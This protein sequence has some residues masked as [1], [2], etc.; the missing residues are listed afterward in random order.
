MQI[1][2]KWKKMYTKYLQHNFVH[3]LVHELV[4]T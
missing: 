3:F 1:L 4:M 2:Q